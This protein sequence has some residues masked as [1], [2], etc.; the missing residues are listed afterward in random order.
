MENQDTKG[1][2]YILIFIG[3]IFA[4][5]GIFCYQ[6]VTWLM[7]GYWE[8]ISILYPFYT[9]GNWMW[10]IYPDTWVGLH[11]ILEMIPLSLTSILLGIILMV[12]SED[13]I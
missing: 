3:L 1:Y 9:F 4:G 7:H 5:L 12:N 6:I 11:K 10:A 8:S 2:V 13:Y